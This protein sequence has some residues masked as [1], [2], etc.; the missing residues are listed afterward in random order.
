VF[1]FHGVGGG[2]FPVAVWLGAWGARVQFA[3][4]ADGGTTRGARHG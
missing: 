2:E 4:F 1:Q 3:N